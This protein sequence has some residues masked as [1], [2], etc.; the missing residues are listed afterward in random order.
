MCVVSLLFCL[1]TIKSDYESFEDSGMTMNSLVVEI[2]EVVN[3]GW[4]CD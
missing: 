2:M 3:V 1:Y 4:L